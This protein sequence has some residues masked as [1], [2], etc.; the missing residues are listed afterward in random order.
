MIAV[1]V[2][3]QFFDAETDEL[4]ADLDESEKRVVLAKGGRGGLGNMNFATPWIAR[5]A[6]RSRANRASH[7]ACGFP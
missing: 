5:R 3:T 1:P 4:I 2:G 6:A 7:G